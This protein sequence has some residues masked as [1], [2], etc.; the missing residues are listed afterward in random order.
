MRVTARILGLA[1]ITLIS[2]TWLTAYGADNGDT[3]S[4]TAGTADYQT[5]QYTSAFGETYHAK[6]PRDRHPRD[7]T[8]IGFKKQPSFVRGG[9]MP[10]KREH[11]MLL[12]AD[13][14]VIPQPLMLG[15]RYGLLYWWDVGFGVGA[16]YGIFQAWVHTRFENIK[17]RESERFFWGTAIRAGYKWHDLTISE[18]V[19]FDDK[20]IITIVENTFALRLGEARRRV[21]YLNSTFYADFDLHTPRRQ[22]DLY[23]MPAGLGFETMVGEHASF[24]L[25]AGMTY[26]INGMEL[27][28]GSKLYEGDWFPV[29]KIGTALRTGKRTAVYYA[30]ETAPLSRGEQPKVLDGRNED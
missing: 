4:D 3:A 20:S 1:A 15:Y 13:G 11:M 16:D 22:T 8:P 21:L 7:Y 29:F 23:V 9:G 24:F 27:A 19:Q 2:T 14:D 6:L 30:R 12:Y 28:D 10:N 5:Y 18:D 25:E 17:T 26:S